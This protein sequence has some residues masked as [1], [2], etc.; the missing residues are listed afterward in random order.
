MKL[1]QLDECESDCECVSRLYVSANCEDL[2]LVS[3]LL[4]H[5]SVIKEK[6]ATRTAVEARDMMKKGE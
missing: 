4:L 3:T 1:K 5:A 2:G 6:A